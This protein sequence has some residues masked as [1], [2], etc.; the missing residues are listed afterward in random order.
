MSPENLEIEASD[1][2]KVTSSWLSFMT[3]QLDA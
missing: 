3:T 1:L 2:A